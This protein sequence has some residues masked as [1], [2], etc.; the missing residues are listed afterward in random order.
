L[1]IIHVH[2]PGTNYGSHFCLSRF[3]FFS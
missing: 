2:Y 3:D 1:T